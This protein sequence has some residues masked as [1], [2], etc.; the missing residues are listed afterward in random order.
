MSFILVSSEREDLQV[1]AWNWRPTLELLFAA[2]LRLIVSVSSEPKKVVFSPDTDVED[3]DTN[4]LYS[5]TLEGLQTFVT[6]CRRSGGFDV[7]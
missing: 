2:G 5:T 6:F 4:D 1:N 3:M 7:M